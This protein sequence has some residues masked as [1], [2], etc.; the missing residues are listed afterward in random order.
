MSAAVFAET[1]RRHVTSI[2]Y[3]S[4]AILVALAGLFASSFNTPASMWPSLVTL[5]SIITGAALIGPEFSTGTLQLI[6]SKPIHRSVY[7]CSRVAGVMASVAIV[8]LIGAASELIARVLRSRVDIPWRSIALVL[9]FEL[10]IAFLAIAILAFLGSVTRSYFNVAIYISVQAVLSMVEALLG[11][12]HLR[13]NMISLFLRRI[14][15][16]DMLF[17]FDNI[18][19]PSLPPQVSVGWPI[20]IAAT[21]LVFVAAACVAFQRREVPYGA[22]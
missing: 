3:V 17:A 21:A 15:A 5:L 2:G 12:F 20:R 13:E 1:V 6:V 19:F 16:E 8:A 10:L 7:V 9:G 22:D 14:D 18:F 4:F 11:V